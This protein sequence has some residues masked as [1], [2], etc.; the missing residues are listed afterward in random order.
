MKSELTLFNFTYDVVLVIVYTAVVAIAVCLYMMRKRHI[1]IPVIGLYACYLVDSL[2]IFMTEALPA[3]NQWYEEGFVY[4]PSIKTIIFLGAAFFTLS[5]WNALL[6]RKF[7][8]IQVAILV[9]LGLYCLMIPLMQTSALKSWLYFL[10]YQV[11]TFLSAI[12]GLW[13]LKRLD[14]ANYDGPFGWIRVVL[15]LTILFSVF[16]VVEDTIVIFNFDSYVVGATTIYARNM[17]ED[18]LR[19]IYTVFFFRLFVKQFRRTWMTAPES[20]NG[21]ALV[22]PIPEEP[23]AEAQIPYHPEAVQDYKKL[24]FAQQLCLTEREVEVFSEM[25]EGKTNQQISDTLCISMGTV[26][27]HIH[28][29]FQKAGVTHR[30]EL[31]RQYD[32]FTPELPAG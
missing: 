15:V 11:F 9:A 31:L 7:S 18:V 5:I 24:K 27:A 16:I 14:N 30:Y 4:S 26:K 20:Y 29:I 25:L 13:K 6:D 23:E 22:E 2:I 17:S 21:G 12:Y 28:N 32:S 19:M 10:S 1:A 8:Q 3:F